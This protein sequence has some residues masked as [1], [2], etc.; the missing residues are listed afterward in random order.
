[1]YNVNLLKK[2]VV[3]LL[4]KNINECYDTKYLFS[5]YQENHNNL[6]MY[7]SFNNGINKL[8]IDVL[9]NYILYLFQKNNRTLKE[10]NVLKKASSFYNE[11]G[12][13]KKSFLL[14]NMI[15]NNIGYLGKSF[16]KDYDVIVEN[17]KS[18]SKEVR[19]YYNLYIN[20]KLNDDLKK[21]R[22]M[23]FLVGKIG[24]NNYKNTLE[25]VFSKLL[26]SN[27]NLLISEK[28]FLVQ[29]ATYVKC[30]RLNMPNAKVYLTKNNLFDG[31]KI[32]ENLKGMSHGT[33][34][35]IGL[36][37]SEFEKDFS[38]ISKKINVNRGILCFTTINHELEHYKQSYDMQ[39]GKLNESS[40]YMIMCCIFRNY[41][42]DKDFN[43]YKTNYE[44][45]QIEREA[46]VNGWR[47]TAKLLQ[48]YAKDTKFK[49]M[50]QAYY[51]SRKT[52]MEK[53]NSWQKKKIN[54]KEKKI[55]IETYNVK[56]L[57]EIIKDNPNLLRNYPQ[58]KEFFDDNGKIYAP[59]TFFE[60]YTK[61]ELQKTKTYDKE[62]YKEL[63]GKLKCYDE[64]ID[65]LFINKSFETLNFDGYNNYETMI[66][67]FSLLGQKF[68]EECNKIKDMC[69]TFD[70]NNLGDFYV[71]LNKRKDRLSKYYNFILKNQALIQ[72]L[73]I[74]N[75]EHLDERH[76]LFNWYLDVEKLNSELKS[77]DRHIDRLKSNNEI[78]KD[79]NYG[80]RI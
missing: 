50:E 52:N 9:E 54:D 2:E 31:K 79:D 48:T 29:Y 41:L 27:K 45:K 22:L 59:F 78:L 32:E 21:I 28:N 80:R 35:I 7:K 3:S 64:F 23:E 56:N 11:L 47:D 38:I 77:V 10:E 24:N 46:N 70:V 75:Q 4:G 18:T 12:K 67:F 8:K 25:N 19:E 58:L 76:R 53:A 42:S 55:T 39:I 13:G 37:E 5:L 66:T 68:F 65:Y 33:T 73:N 74:Y 40:F 60:K 15:F 71:I 63:D 57:I 14:N 61:L 51:I 16:F 62:E 36:N 43:E 72:K 20:D 1:M 26:N 17:I 49:E 34:G 69:N 30:Q 6:Y 44:Y